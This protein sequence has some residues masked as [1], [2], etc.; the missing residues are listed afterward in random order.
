M[1]Q[2]FTVNRFASI[3]IAS[4]LVLATVAIA[5]DAPAKPASL[6]EQMRLL[7]PATP[8]TTGRAWLVCGEFPLAHEPDELVPEETMTAAAA[9]DY[10]QSRGGEAAIRPVDGWEHKRPD[11]TAAAWKKFAAKTDA[12]DFPG[13]LPLR[14]GDG[15]VWYAFT[16]VTRATAGKAT[17][18]L[19]CR[20][21]TKM[22][23]NGTLVHEHAPLPEAA[24]TDVFPVTFHAGENAILVK[25]IQQGPCT[26]TFNV[27]EWAQAQM[28]EMTAP[29]LT[30]AILPPSVDAPNALVVSTFDREH[31]LL[32][33]ATPITVS[34]N[35]PGGQTVGTKRVARGE[36]AVFDTAA[37]PDGAYEIR[38]SI[39]DANGRIG[40][41]YL[42]WYKGDALAAARRLVESAG[43]A[44]AERSLRAEIVLAR[45]GL[46]KERAWDRVTP[47]L[48]PAI[49]P[50][51]L[52]AAVGARPLPDRQTG[53]LVR[54][55][56][57]DDTDDSQQFCR[58][59]LPPGYDPAKRYPVIVFLH[60]RAD[61]FPPYAQW[62][63]V[64]NRHDWLSERNDAITLYPH[65]RGNTWYRG[66][67]DRDVM[68]CL[69]MVEARFSVD[70]NR[71]YLY[72]VS[73]GGAGVWYVGT[74][75]PDRFA[76]L[77]PFY[78]GF[79]YRFQYKE[80]ALAK[81]T[82]KEQFRRERYSYIAQAEAL[83]TTP[84][85][86]SHGDD[87]P[88]VPVDY[89][90]YTVRLLERWGYPVRYWEGP[91]VKHASL[92]N[93]REVQEWLLAQR[94]QPAPAHVTLRALELRSATAH[95]VTVLQRKSPYAAVLADAEVLSP[96]AL[97]LNTDNVLEI[98][99]TP[100]P[101][102]L[103][104]TKPV[105]V[106]WNNDTLL[107]V[108]PVNGRLTLR[109][110]G[111]VPAPLAKR[112]ELEGPV[113]DLY[114]TPFAVVVGTMSPDPLMRA[115]CA[116]AA[117]RYCD[118]WA[119]RFH[120]RPRCFVDTAMTSTEQAKYSL[121]LIGGPGENAVAA[122]MAA[123]LPFA[124]ETLVSGTADPTIEL[125][126]SSYSA[127][128]RIGD[129]GFIARNAAVQMIYPNP[130]NPDRYVVLRA[131]S[132]PQAMALTD[133]VHNDVDFCIVDSRNVDPGRAG[134]FFDAIVGRGSGTP[135][136]AGYFDNR[137]KIVDANLE[138]D[139]APRNGPVFTAPKYP[140]AAVEG[141]SLPLGDVV[142]T[143]AGGAFLD[144][145]R[146]TNLQFA[147]LTL[148]GKRYADGLATAPAYWLPKRESF[149]EYAL[150]GTAWTRLRGVIGLEVDP[151]PEAVKAVKAA[152]IAVEFVVKGDGVELY[153]S[154]PFGYATPPATL[155]VDLTGVNV[156][157]LE[158]LNKGSGAQV[159]AVDWANLHL[160][161]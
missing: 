136:V 34:L 161:R 134:G 17:L 55:C 129:R 60:G 151:S 108:T 130:L 106:L 1:I 141:A 145:T 12:V 107:T 71:V 46:E 158:I 21:M 81:L 65:A 95:W 44:D 146:N 120:S 26:I 131:A 68:R 125:P 70:R 154:A 142:E 43:D 48:L 79:D 88:V 24:Y 83:R 93:E 39:T 99:L 97:R 115:M 98:A 57:R 153:H 22:W 89:S 104:A 82:P 33:N 121:L 31:N 72:G 66:L 155:D 50:T 5:A 78:G 25:V 42:P 41:A 127:R 56:Y 86:A 114:N 53:G 20:S 92:G 139:K 64:D 19:G 160:E 45:L 122:Q 144:M 36:Q 63:G 6:K 2:E 58:V 27:L 51:L 76:A 74:R 61:T 77:A 13:A 94:L 3:V 110:P 9:N 124:I 8:A 11:G 137:W 67:G 119:E 103:D 100:P 147:P 133:Y 117:R 91:G 30:P 90:H 135:I 85:L 152:P 116:R 105:Q 138:Q 73:M 140:S 35:T 52:D 96:H 112:P 156:L 59:Y 159:K 62:G 18:I 126:A 132:N 29:R 54:L 149:V 102:L 10:L 7:W 143:A 148:A 157:R 37:L 69:D 47:A 111:Y 40:N 80:D 123:K 118:A 49:Y 28:M 23:V 4:L 84:V 38:L 87:D 16:T 113:T 109:A 150:A 128:F 32:L 14:P 101:A 75:H 15:A